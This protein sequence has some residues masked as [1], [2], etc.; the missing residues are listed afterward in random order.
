[1]RL[2]PLILIFSNKAFIGDFA[3]IADENDYET[4]ASTVREILGAHGLLE[5]NNEVLK[6]AAVRRRSAK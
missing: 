5:G 2:P 3:E 6:K 4:S 1:M